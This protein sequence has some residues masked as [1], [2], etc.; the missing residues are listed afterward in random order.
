MPM[1]NSKINVFEIVLLVVGVGVAVL[2]FQLI[3]QT[4]QDGGGQ[5]SWLMI[6]SI[7]SWLTLLVL[8]ILLSLMV[9]VSKKELTEIKTMISLL[10]EKKNKK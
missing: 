3:N 7:F 10:A 2:G 6:I 8:F 5:L 9:D 1:P 4:Y